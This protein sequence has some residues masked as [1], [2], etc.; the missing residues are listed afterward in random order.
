MRA[1]IEGGDEWVEVGFEMRG[2]GVGGAGD[3]FQ[4]GPSRLERDG[5]W[6]WDLGFGEGVPCFWTWLP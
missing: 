6:I 2:G 5:V 4:S 3:P 1:L